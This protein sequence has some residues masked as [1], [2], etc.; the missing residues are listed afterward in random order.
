[1]AASRDLAEGEEL[2]L[3]SARSLHSYELMP[4]YRTCDSIFALRERSS[5][6]V[7]GRRRVPEEPSIV[8]S[9]ARS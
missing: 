8:S 6:S 1:M 9:E 3:M 4:Q 2:T 7:D 5:K